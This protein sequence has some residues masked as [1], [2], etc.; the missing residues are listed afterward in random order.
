MANKNLFRKSPSV[1]P[2]TDTTNA[3]GGVAY[4]LPPKHALAQLA[5]TGCFNSTFHANA[6]TQLTTLLAL[7]EQVNDAP[8]LAKLAVYSRERAFMKDMPVAL[9][10]ALSKRD[11]VLFHRAF[12]RV[13]DNGK[14]LRNVFQMLRSGMFGRKSLS[15]SLQRAF[16]RFLNKATTSDLLTA[17]IGNDPSLRDVL[18]MARPTPTDNE[19]RALYGW[20]VNKPTLDAEPPVEVK[21]LL[22]FRRAETADEQIDILERHR[23]RWDLLA[24]TAKGPGV[25]VAIAKQMGLQAL[26]MNLNTLM[27]HQVFEQSPDVIDAV[28]SR[29]RDPEAIRRA[30]QFPYQFFA[31]Y[32]N[33]EPGLPTSIRDALQEAAEIAC[34]NV[35]ELPGPIVVG[36]DVSGSMKSPVTGRRGAG[37]T[38]TMRCVDVAALFA[39][40]ILRRNPGSVIVPFD[41]EPHAEITEFSGSILELAAQLSRYGGGGTNCS[42]PLQYANNRLKKRQF[43]GCVIVSDNESWVGT[44][45]GGSTAVM[46]QW[47][48]FVANRNRSRGG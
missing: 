18:R 10:L 26:R 38:S 1:P 47:S 20:L 25:W 46:A 31:A 4:R 5:A 43:G 36:L 33:A 37:A 15:Y 9:L 3:A 22:A 48:D 41:T 32:L 11:T 8:F 44:G 40:A 34:G 7:I 39:A 12:D 23:F 29:L 27:R 30:R 19:R 17:S 2:V 24:D 35:P 45:R 16:N 28:A 6:E 13:V 21:A 14:M 42:I